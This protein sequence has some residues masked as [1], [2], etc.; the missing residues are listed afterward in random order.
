VPFLGPALSVGS[1]DL[2]SDRDS[3]HGIFSVISMI[4]QLLR[5]DTMVDYD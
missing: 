1:L 4:W 3:S 2:W 5:S